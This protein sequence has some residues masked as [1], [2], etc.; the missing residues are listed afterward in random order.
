MID[1]VLVVDDDPSMLR[2]LQRLLSVDGH[3]VFTAV[4]GVEALRQ[5]REEAIRL[6]VTDWMMPA[7]GGLEICRAIRASKSTQSIYVIVLTG[8]ADKGRLVEAFEA[9]AD[10][11]VSKPP[12]R[13]ELLAR[14]RAGERILRLQDELVQ[15]GR[16]AQERDQLRAAVT[17]FEQVLGIVSHELRTPLAG[18]R[19]MTEFLLQKG[20]RTTELLDSYLSNIHQQV[21]HMADT[22]NNLLDATRFNSGTVPWRWSEFAVEEVCREAMD[23]IT[24]L[25]DPA[26]VE[27]R[28]Q[29]EPRGLTMRGDSEAI[30][31][32]LINLL[33]NAQKHTD[34]GSVVVEITARTAERAKWVQIEVRDTGRGID[35][36]IADR[37]GVAFALGAGALGDRHVSGSGLGLSICRGIVAAHGGKLHLSSRKGFGTTVRALLRAD[38]PEAITAGEV[39]PI[40]TEV[41]S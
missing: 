24:P 31:R 22:I 27:L 8:H 18:T 38:L 11:F 13:E 25:V 1:G 39:P 10:D 30:R 35:S 2:L 4:N 6:V 5:L 9:G 16:I 28:V 20:A 19:A 21:V 33:S 3:R 40:A 23:T 29:V 26:K 34:V 17:A 36:R 32:L 7:M 12:D 14:V 15:Q 41:A 37:L